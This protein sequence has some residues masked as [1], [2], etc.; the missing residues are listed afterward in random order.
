MEPGLPELRSSLSGWANGCPVSGYYWEHSKCADALKW[1][2]WERQTKYNLQ[3][4]YMGGV[5]VS[6]WFP[7]S[8]LTE[9]TI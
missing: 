2:G 3:E 1:L 8:P 6:S 7:V 9:D 4:E 5:S